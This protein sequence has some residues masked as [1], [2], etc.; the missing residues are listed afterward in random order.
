[1]TVQLIFIKLSWI[2]TLRFSHGC[3]KTDIL[4]TITW[5]Y[6]FQKSKDYV[7]LKFSTKQL[8]AAIWFKY[9]VSLLNT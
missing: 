3:H 4:N 6:A 7:S 5:K 9:F 2:P 8:K 1:M